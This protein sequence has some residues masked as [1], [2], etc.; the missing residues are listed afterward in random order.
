MILGGSALRILFS[1]QPKLHSWNGTP[2]TFEIFLYKKFSQNIK[3]S[4]STFIAVFVC[5]G[6]LECTKM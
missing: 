4:G 6:M 5:Q 3:V 2:G 1:E